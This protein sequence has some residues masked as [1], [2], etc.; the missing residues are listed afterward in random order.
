MTAVLPT[1][2][3]LAL[4]VGSDPY[5][6][7]RV[8]TGIAND[9]NAHCLWWGVPNVSFQQ[10]VTGNPETTGDNEF[11]AGRASL[12]EWATANDTCG[13]LVISEGPR[14]AQRDIA[15]DQ[16]NILLYRMTYCP[17]VAPSSDACWKEETCMNKYDCW[18]GE[19]GTIALTTT[20]YDLATGQIYDADIEMN[21]AWFVF[22]TV[23]SPPCVHPVY[24]QSCIAT[25]VE[26]TMTH[27]LGH[28]LGLDH[29]T[30]PDSTMNPSAP[31][32]ET[33]KRSLDE[34]SRDFICEV[35]PKDAPARDCVI[36]PVNEVLGDSAGCS[37][38]TAAPLAP[39]A[40]WGWALLRRRRT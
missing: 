31:A 16:K 39:L 14:I 17:D 34:G 18:M 21:G 22:T 35:Y 8:E 33:K 11:T 24:S 32:G 7:S 1:L 19:K 30:F 27:E 28:A 25:D 15:Y 20:T 6:R 9:Q 38:A 29:T 36:T 23:D 26:N 12:A 5:V 37:A 10:E 2:V 40:L 4:G 13:H 3:A